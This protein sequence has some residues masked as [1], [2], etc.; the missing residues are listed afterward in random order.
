MTL[1]W[2]PVYARG[3]NHSARRDLQVQVRCCW[4]ERDTM[5]WEHALAGLFV[6][7]Y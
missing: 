6:Q 4:G 3:Q 5:P 7:W 2:S 1:A